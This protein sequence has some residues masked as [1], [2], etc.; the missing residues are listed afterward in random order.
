MSAHT[1]LNGR[2]QRYYLFTVRDIIFYQF[3]NSRGHLSFDNTN[4]LPQITKHGAKN[5]G[6]LLNARP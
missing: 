2:L 1:S 6:S 5:Y 3:M 4:C